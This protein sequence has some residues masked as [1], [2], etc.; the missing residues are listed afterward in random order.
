MRP[1]TSQSLV[2]DNHT[3]GAGSY[4]AFTVTG[5]D[6]STVIGLNKVSNNF[7]I[8]IGRSQSPGTTIQTT[9]RVR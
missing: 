9:I 4:R 6:G 7:E 5:L 8:F 2:T 1:I 3:G